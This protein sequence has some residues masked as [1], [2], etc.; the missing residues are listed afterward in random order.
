MEPL[1]PIELLTI[2]LYWHIMLLDDFKEQ[3]LFAIMD[4]VR[5]GSRRYEK[6]LCS[7][8]KSKLHF[9][10]LIIDKGNILVS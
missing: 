6:I 3:W 9:V 4:G 8:L 2:N 1:W 5:C 7:A 10:P